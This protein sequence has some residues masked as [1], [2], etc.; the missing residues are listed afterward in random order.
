[1]CLYSYSIPNREF[2]I[3]TT[4]GVLGCRDCV[5]LEPGIYVNSKHPDIC[6][7]GRD[8]QYYDVPKNFL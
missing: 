3:R 5:V 2:S 8:L 4:F 7:A 1:M 6:S